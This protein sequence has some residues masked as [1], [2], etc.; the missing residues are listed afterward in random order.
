M[1]E[2]SNPIANLYPQPPAAGGG[3]LLS[4]PFGP[5]D[6]ISRLQQLSLVG[7]TL[8]AKQAVGDAYSHNINPDGTPNFPGIAAELKNNPAAAFGMQEAQ[9]TL[10]QQYGQNIENNTRAFSQFAAQNGFAQQWL[11]SRANDPNA[12]KEDILNDAVTLARNT[13]PRVMP[14]SVITGVISTILNDP[15]GVHGGLVNLQNRVMGA[16]AAAQRIQGPPA[17]SGAPTTIPLGSAGYVGQVP[18]GTPPGTEQSAQ[19]MQADLAHARNF[20][21]EIFPWQQALEKLEELGPGGTGPGSKGRQEFQSYLFALNPTIARWAGV[22][23]S[24]LQNYAEAEKYLTQATQ[25]RAAGFGAD[26]NMKLA[27]AISGSPNIHINQLSNVDVTRAAIA[28]RRMEQVQTLEASRS[29]APNYT[30]AAANISARLDPRAF[31]IDMMQPEQIIHLQKT[32]K[33]PERAQFNRSLQMAIEDGVI[34]APG[35]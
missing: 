9:S 33:G 8:A 34:S 22:D 31:A 12:S 7:R 11:A 21:Q 18:V 28:L 3:N 1:P 30:N 16:G 25:T 29:G 17:P 4:D 20:N 23:P 14:S 26:T 10:L 5:I 13:D 15:N 27:T 35:R 6:A 32:L 24:K 2:I 19:T